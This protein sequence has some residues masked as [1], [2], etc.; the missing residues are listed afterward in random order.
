MEN[1]HEK[2]C[3]ASLVIG[4]M[5]IKMTIRYHLIPTRL[6]ILRHLV[7]SSMRVVELQWES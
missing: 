1:K 3:L 5:L 6:A 7:I 2:K 4:A